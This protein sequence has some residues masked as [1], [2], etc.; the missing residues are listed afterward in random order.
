[1]NGDSPTVTNKELVNLLLSI[2][3]EKFS[4]RLKAVLLLGNQ[5]MLVKQNRKHAIDGTF[6]IW[7]IL[8]VMEEAAELVSSGSVELECDSTHHSRS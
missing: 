1:M 8:D 3:G 2:L 7:K 6:N 5:S 4:R